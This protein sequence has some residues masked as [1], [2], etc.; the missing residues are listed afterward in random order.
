MEKSLD[1]LISRIT[2]IKK[3]TISEFTKNSLTIALIYNAADLY[4][5]NKIGLSSYQIMLAFIP[6]ATTIYQ[7]TNNKYLKPK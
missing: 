3:E 2:P 6:T 7:H 5:Q 1:Q 4:I